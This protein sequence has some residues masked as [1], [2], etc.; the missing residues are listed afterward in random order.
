RTPGAR[1]RAEQ[2]ALAGLRIER[3]QFAGLVAAAGADGHDLALGGL[4]FGGVRN[5][6][7]AGGFLLSIDALDDDAVVKRAEFH[8]Y[9]PKCLLNREF[10]KRRPC[11]ESPSGRPQLT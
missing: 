10:L 1:P 7:A 11:V 3:N 6:D 8:G 9:P 5:D 2:H 4:L